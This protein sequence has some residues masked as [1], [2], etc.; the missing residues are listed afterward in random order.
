M[1][2][3]VSLDIVD[4]A[5]LDGRVVDRMSDDHIREV[6]KRCLAKY[7]DNH[8]VNVSF[9]RFRE[10]FDWFCPETTLEYNPERPGDLAEIYASLIRDTEDTPSI[11]VCLERLRS[12]SEEFWEAFLV[13]LEMHPA[14]SVSALVYAENVGI[15][16]Y[17]L[18]QRFEK[19]AVL[20]RDCVQKSS[21][22]WMGVRP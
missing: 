14:I 3:T 1:M 12:A 21:W 7:P 2:D 20:V 16:R 15:T 22:L 9:G 6:R 19:A 17:Q 18:E 11:H 4:G 5:Y 10:Y 13:K 8:N